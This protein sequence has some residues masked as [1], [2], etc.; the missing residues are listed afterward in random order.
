MLFLFPFIYILLSL[1]SAVVFFRTLYINPIPRFSL[2]SLVFF[3]RISFT[4]HYHRVRANSSK[5][6]R[7]LPLQ[8]DEY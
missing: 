6:A 1:C 4:D 7:L 2:F 8:A 3:S 5:H